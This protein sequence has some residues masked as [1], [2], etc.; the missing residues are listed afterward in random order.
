MERERERVVEILLFFFWWI[1]NFAIEA[2]EFITCF[3][4]FGK[5]GDPKNPFHKQGNNWGHS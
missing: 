3:A 2:S 4:D 5:V 1:G